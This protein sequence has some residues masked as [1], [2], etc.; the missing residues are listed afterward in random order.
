MLYA[1]TGGILTEDGTSAYE[2]AMA[3]GL[4]TDFDF[5]ELKLSENNGK[6]LMK[7]GFGIADVSRE[8]GAW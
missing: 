6:S 3:R 2:A 4:R 5:I 8:V 7:D 1:I